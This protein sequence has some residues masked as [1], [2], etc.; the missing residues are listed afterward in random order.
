MKLATLGCRVQGPGLL[1]LRRDCQVSAFAG[2]PLEKISGNYPL[3]SPLK[4]LE[5]T[6]QTI[7]SANACEARHP[8][9]FDGVSCPMLNLALAK[10]RCLQKESRSHAQK[11][12]DNEE[13]SVVLL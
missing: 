10:A 3:L 12:S 8:P 9:L 5:D 1:K 4:D 6:P 13:P 11:Q 7:H 2:T